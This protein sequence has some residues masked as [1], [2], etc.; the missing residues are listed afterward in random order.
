M[1]F[2]TSAEERAISFAIASVTKNVA[3]S[4]WNLISKPKFIRKS[5]T[6]KSVVLAAEKSIF[7]EFPAIPTVRRSGSFSDNCLAALDD[8]VVEP[9][10][11]AHGQ[12]SRRASAAICHEGKR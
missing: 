2:Q 1:S 11:R 3:R 8:C 7:A 12:A 4:P 6:H 5:A 9:H 10:R